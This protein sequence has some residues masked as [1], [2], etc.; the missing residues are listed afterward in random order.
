[1]AYN[2][3]HS[4]HYFYLA[5]KGTQG[6]VSV[7]RWSFY[8]SLDLL[9]ELEKFLKSYETRPRKP[10][11]AGQL[12]DYFGGIDS[13]AYEHHMRQWADYWRA[14]DLSLEH[15]LIRFGHR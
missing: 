14:P 8:E 11:E 4:C 9:E 3:Y 12:I 7:I 13:R 10:K 1:M 5:R 6:T 2:N 15:I